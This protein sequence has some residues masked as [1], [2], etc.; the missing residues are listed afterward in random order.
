MWALRFDEA[1][2]GVTRIQFSKALAAEGFP[3]EIGYVRPLYRLPL[4]QKRVAIGAQGYPFNLTSIRYDEVACPVTERMHEKELLTF[5][6]CLYDV[7]EASARLLGEALQKVH[8][9]RHE[10]VDRERTATL[11]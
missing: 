2:L 6:P 3:N 1:A 8:A 7:D 4:F 10:L 11:G 5:E 9:H